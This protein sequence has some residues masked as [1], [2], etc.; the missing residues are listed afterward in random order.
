MS[1]WSPSTTDSIQKRTRSSATT[2]K[3]VLWIPLKCVMDIGWRWSGW[4]ER[5]SVH[6]GSTSKCSERKG[7]PA[8]HEVDVHS[9]K[10]TKVRC[11]VVR[12]MKAR[13]WEDEE[14][15]PSVVFAAM[16]PIQL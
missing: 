8:R 14:L 5:E 15:N 11:V 16:L 1:S 6:Q 10:A 13:S 9:E 4:L 3:E 7:K 2:S 12:E